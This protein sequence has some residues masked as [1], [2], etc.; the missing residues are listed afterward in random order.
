MRDSIE[1]YHGKSKLVAS[2]QSSFRINVGDIINIRK[3]TWEVI[4]VTF[5]LDNADYPESTAMRCNVDLTPME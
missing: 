5:A 1:F 4:R 2:S 3:K